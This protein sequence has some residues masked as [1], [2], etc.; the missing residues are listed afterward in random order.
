MLT[1]VRIQSIIC[2][3]AALPPEC[4]AVT[5]SALIVDDSASARLVLKRVLETHGIAVDACESAES[6]LDYL[7]EHRPDAIFM[8]HLMPG[9]DGFEAVRVIKKNPDTAMI[10]IM[11]YTSQEGEVFVGQARALGAVGV[12]PKTVKP[13][14]VSKILAS[15]HLVEDEPDP[16][17]A[18]GEA[19]A[20]PD[21]KSLLEGLFD[22]Q[23]DLLQQEL[24]QTYTDLT[25]RFAAELALRDEAAA[26]EPR[27]E[28][29]AD[30]GWFRRYGLGA[31]V[32]AALLLAVVASWQR[33]RIDDLQADNRELAQQV[34]EPV[35]AVAGAS[36][37]G[38]VPADRGTALFDALEWGANQAGYYA[39]DEIP[40]GSRRMA[41]FEELVT[42]LAA[43]GFTGVITVDVHVGNYCMMTDD[44]GTLRLAPPD[45][46]AAYCDRVGFDEAEALELGYE[47]SIAFA[48][49]VIMTEERSGGT[50][51]FDIASQGNS[52]PR[53]AYPASPS[54]VAAGDWNAVAA[55]NNRVEV[56]LL[57]DPG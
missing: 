18:R 17:A 25:E 56:T 37:A 1:I 26:N 38:P 34:I 47:Q 52:Q 41:I 14:E 15:L 39:F 35:Q 8:D 22:Q 10:P 21:L 28:T 54:G 16:A 43:A 3:N 55:A 44:S 23:R 4:H 13:V 40:L 6:A 32:M 42:Q 9:M 53:V 27:A 33:V 31:A 36:P 49:F 24:R 50:L 12:L 51:R 2:R 20:D 7:D 57:P 19:P 48:N 29:G 45:V 30:D 46:D 11:M 5:K